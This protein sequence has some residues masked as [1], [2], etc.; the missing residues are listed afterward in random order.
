MESP[1]LTDKDSPR[2]DH[3]AR[4]IS[5]AMVGLFKDYVGR[6]PTVAKTYIHDDLV[7]CVLH[8]TMTRAE[9]T[10]NAEGRA[11]EVR[12]LRRS[13]QD[14][15]REQASREIERIVGRPVTA[16]LSDHAVDPDYAIE[17][18]VLKPPVDAGG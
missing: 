5:R 14:L 2:G 13:F 15:F 7:V 16:F 1:A 4:E 17:A 10:L 3:A 8:D 9:R 6:G 11:D 18:F 12:S